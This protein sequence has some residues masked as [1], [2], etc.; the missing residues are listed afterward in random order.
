VRL[1][2]DFARLID[3]APEEVFDA[4]TAPEGQEAFYGQDDPGWIV[5][6]HCD[7]RVGGVWSVDFGPSPGELYRHRHVFEL[8]E[9]PHR[10]LLASTE[11]RL[12]GSSFHTK[13][14]FTFE[15]KGEKTLMTMTQ[16]GF[17]T[18]ELRDE[19]ARGLPNAFTRL[20]RL[21]QLSG[22]PTDTRHDRAP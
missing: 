5:R 12:D 15:A 19:H 3:A 8:T 7:L 2:V 21:I 16:R 22:T 10:L 4:F 11:T 17:P 6:S 1:D 13:L 9:R 14:E 20:E 18:A